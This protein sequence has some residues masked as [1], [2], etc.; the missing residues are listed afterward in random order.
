MQDATPT[1]KTFVPQSFGSIEEGMA[2]Y[3][4]RMG[5]NPF[6]QH[7]S[8]CLGEV[9]ICPEGESF[10]LYDAR[11]RRQPV[12]IRREDGLSFLTLTGGRP[13][14]AFVIISEGEWRLI[15]IWYD[16]HYRITQHEYHTKEY[17]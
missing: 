10:A 8:L 15:S 11:G 2:Y 6:A 17:E 4:E 16:G 5:Q 3:R 12:S 13:C 7:T 1:E 9:R 14:N